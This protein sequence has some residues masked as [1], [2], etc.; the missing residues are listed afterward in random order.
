MLCGARYLEG[1][2]RVLIEVKVKVKFT[3]HQAR[4]AQRGSRCIALLS[5][6]SV[7]DGLGS[8]RHASAALPL[9]VTL[10]P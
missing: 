2:D 4:K 5:L 1:N 7:L 9:E 10:Y 6:T 3:L 8:Q